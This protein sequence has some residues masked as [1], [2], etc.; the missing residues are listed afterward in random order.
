MKTLSSVRF[1]DL[2]AVGQPLDGGDFAGIITEPD[3]THVAVVLL[4]EQGS[5]L[6]HSRALAWAKKQRGALLTRPI[7][8][9]LFANL[10]DR[11]RP[12]WHWTSEKYGASYAWSCPFDNGG[13][14]T[15]HES[16]PCSAVA[17]RCIPLV[18]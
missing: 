17:V 7:A 9:L 2:P 6:T 1:G 13:Q 15:S 12:E 11:L 8:A 16:F 18:P 14:G 5:D 4:P 10:R 3:G